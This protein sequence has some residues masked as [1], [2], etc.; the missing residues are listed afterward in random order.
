MKKTD[1]QLL[2]NLCGAFAL[3]GKYLRA[4]ESLNKLKKLNPNFPGAANLRQQLNNVIKKN[5]K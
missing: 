4:D 3:S 5:N 2:F 1:Q